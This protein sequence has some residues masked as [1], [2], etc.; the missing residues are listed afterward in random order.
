[1]LNNE[2]F[3]EHALKKPVLVLHLLGGELLDE[4]QNHLEDAIGVCLH[5][6]KTLA[7]GDFCC[8]Y[9]YTRPGSSARKKAIHQ[10]L[11]VP[12]PPV[13][14]TFSQDARKRAPATISAV[15]SPR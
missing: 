3:I 13:S 4:F 8:D 7:T 1:M 2:L 10:A 11:A 14:P 6:D 15:P 12:Y 9:L 5:R